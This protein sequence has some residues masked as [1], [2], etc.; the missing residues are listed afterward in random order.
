MAIPLKEVNPILEK[1]GELINGEGVKKGKKTKSSSKSNKEDGERRA[2]RSESA[3]PEP[4]APSPLPSPA[5]ESSEGEKDIKSIKESIQSLM[6][7]VSGLTK[8]VNTVK[9]KQEEYEIPLF[10]G[11]DDDYEFFE[12]EEDMEV[13]ELPPQKRARS[14]D[15]EPMPSTSRGNASLLDKLTNEFELEEKTGDDINPRFAEIIN[16]FLSKGFSVDALD[17]MD[18]I[19]P[20]NLEYLQKVKV[21]GEL[22]SGLGSGVRSA[23]LKLQ[24]IQ[25]MV[26]KSMI[27]IIQVANKCLDATENKAEMPQPEEIF[28][29]L[30]DAI[31]MLA[32]TSHTICMNRRNNI[33]PQL[34]EQYK[35]LCAPVN[36]VTSELFGDNLSAAAKD[37]N[38]TNRLTQK[39]SAGD[40]SFKFRTRGQ[41]GQRRYN[42]PTRSVQRYGRQ[43]FLP[44]GGPWPPQA[45]RQYRPMR[46]V[47]AK[48][49]RTARN[50]Q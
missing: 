21:N 43:G 30:R 42:G 27:P 38:E 9:R 44:R 2:L 26:I 41:G 29:N 47:V 50:A 22:W 16:A 13:E 35:S 28:N 20:K 46:K 36:P 17:N 48:T 8:T 24:N 34:K 40:Q 12:R 1:M 31:A 49:T 4:R 3:N 45:A 10:Y 33:K 39:M 32:N 7:A 18:Y 6:V 19:R 14:D 25:G 11:D 37:L 23:D 15:S 5:S